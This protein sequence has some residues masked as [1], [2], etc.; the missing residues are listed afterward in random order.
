MPEMNDNDLRKLFQAAGHAKPERDLTNRIMARVAVTRIAE[1]V[2]V[3][4]LISKRAWV[5]IAIATGLF[6][7]C[8]LSLSGLGGTNPS[9]PWMDHLLDGVA[10]LK[11]PEGARRK[12]PCRARSARALAGQ[13]GR[14]TRP[15]RWPTRVG[16]S[17]AKAS[18]ATASRGNSRITVE[19]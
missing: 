4:P 2:V 10:Q 14:R 16:V 13:A 1:P 3:A 5:T 6:F 19:P 18:S 9:F 12:G 8:A 7:L 17:V 11:M 15:R